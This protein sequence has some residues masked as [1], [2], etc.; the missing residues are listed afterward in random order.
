MSDKKSFLLHILWHICLRNCFIKVAFFLVA[1]SN[2]IQFLFFP[3][4]HFL[5][6]Q[7]ITFLSLGLCARHLDIMVAISQR[8]WSKSISVQKEKNYLNF[9]LQRFVLHVDS[10]T[11]FRWR[12]E[13]HFSL[14]LWNLLFT[15]NEQRQSGLDNVIYI[16]CSRLSQDIHHL[17]S[18]VFVF[19]QIQLP[20][21]WE[22]FS[23]DKYG[24]RRNGRKWGYDALR[25]NTNTKKN[26]NT[27][28][29]TDIDIGEAVGSEDMMLWGLSSPMTR[30]GSRDQS[31]LLCPKGK[32]K[33][34]LKG[35]L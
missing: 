32:K 21:P 27:N 9:H 34:L 14:E 1:G 13:I 35:E 29:N 4:Q 24:Y 3:L 33:P 16:H 22:I 30:G 7:E 18:A 12:T 23:A 19:W 8:E 11:L 6:W 26:I 15:T 31:A 20:F 5:K 10:V 25:K 17:F 28:I 2:N